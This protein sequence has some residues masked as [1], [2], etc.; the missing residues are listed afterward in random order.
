M[1][2][3]LSSE[4]STAICWNVVTD[5]HIDSHQGKVLLLPGCRKVEDRTIGRN[6]FGDFSGD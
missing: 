1:K 2:G 6:G 3:A 5:T 4:L